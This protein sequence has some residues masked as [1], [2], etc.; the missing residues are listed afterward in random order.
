MLKSDEP[1]LCLGFE[2]WDLGFVWDLSFGICDFCRG[3]GPRRG[4]AVFPLPY[5]VTDVH[6]HVQVPGDIDP[7]VERG[8][9]FGIT[10]FGLSAVFIGGHSPTPAQCREGND[11]VL[12]ARDRQP[13]AALPFCYV[14]PCH[15][16]EAVAEIGRCVAGHGMVGIKLWI[17]AKASE[18]CVVPVAER[19]AELGVPVL[20]HTW[21]KV[22]QGYEH[23]STPADL[24]VLARRVPQA[25][26]IMAHLFGGG[27]R[28]VADIADCP[29]VY[30]DCCGG[31]AE[32]GRLEEAVA[33]L[34]A[35]RILYGS[36]GAG[37]SFATQLG[38]VLGAL[39]PE[40]AK[41]LILSTNAERLFAGKEQP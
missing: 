30:A 26:F 36:D 9:R 40:D 41:R 29:N 7:L 27:Q 21:Y 5:P 15:T 34:G 2:T 33:R 28:G 12:A 6:V 1:L 20:Q 25:T 18:E 39:L 35:E 8:A 16:A 13:A 17:A 3:H 24:A 32:V 23:E 31:E 22:V 14:N 19:A 11:I 38:K 10:R 37:R 4:N